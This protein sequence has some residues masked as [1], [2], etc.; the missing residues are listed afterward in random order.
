MVSRCLERAGT[1]P[2]TGLGCGAC[3]RSLSHLHH[4]A[5]LTQSLSSGSCA[6]VQITPE[7]PTDSSR[8]GIWKAYLFSRAAVLHMDDSIW[9]LLPMDCLGTG[10]VV[11][12]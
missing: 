12:D 2:V 7:G 6:F 8:E 4:V 1:I 5:P 10:G 11:A 9:D 3:G